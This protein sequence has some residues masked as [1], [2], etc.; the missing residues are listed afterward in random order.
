[1]QKRRSMKTKSRLHVLVLVPIIAS[2]ALGAHAQ[3]TAFHYQG[4]LNDNGKPATGSYDLAF[5][6]Y[7]SASGG[8]AV[9]NPQTVNAVGVTNGAFTVTLDFG[10]TVFT[11]AA[12]WVELAV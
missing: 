8:S 12:R 10:S 3:G 9:G 6:V 11:G 2:L 7:D 5:A 1:K 4:R